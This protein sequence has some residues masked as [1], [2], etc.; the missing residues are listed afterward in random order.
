MLN[1]ARMVNRSRVLRAFPDPDVRS[2]IRSDDQKA[3]AAE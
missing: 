1:G 2:V 3:A